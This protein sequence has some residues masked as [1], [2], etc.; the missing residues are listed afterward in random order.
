V[1]I[2]TVTGGKIELA[3]LENGQKII[4]GCESQKAVWRLFAPHCLIFFK[5]EVK[6]GKHKR[7]MFWSGFQS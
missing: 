5:K 6:N 4:Q 1:E 3:K 2:K 7:R